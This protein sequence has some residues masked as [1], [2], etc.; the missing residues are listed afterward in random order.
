MPVRKKRA[1]SKP[2]VKKPEIEEKE[3]GEEYKMIADALKAA[4]NKTAALLQDIRDQMNL[5]RLEQAQPPVEWVF[6]VVRDDNGYIK[7]IRATTPENKK[8]L[9]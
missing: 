1:I 4:S 7:T 2:E 9:N 5:Q 6:D 3:S 8:T